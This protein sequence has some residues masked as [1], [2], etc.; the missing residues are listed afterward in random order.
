MTNKTTV[1]VLKK[2]GDAN[3][4]DLKVCFEYLGG[5]YAIAKLSRTQGPASPIVGE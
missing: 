4:T 2:E 1:E 5:H 3:A